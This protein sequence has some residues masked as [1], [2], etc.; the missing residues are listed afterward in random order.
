MRIKQTN[1][2]TNN[3]FFCNALAVFKSNIYDVLGQKKQEVIITISYLDKTN[4][5]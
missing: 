4:F 3:S 5:L 1:K 2:Q